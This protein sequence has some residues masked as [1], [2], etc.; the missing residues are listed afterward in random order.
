MENTITSRVE[1][2][3]PALTLS[4]A[5]QD[6]IGVSIQSVTIQ[7]PTLMHSTSNKLA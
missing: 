5:R 1:T 4:E 6:Y 7:V 3:H 2:V